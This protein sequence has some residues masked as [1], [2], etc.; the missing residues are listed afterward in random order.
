MLH[1]G[2]LIIVTHQNIRK[3]FENFYFCAVEGG[4]LL[5]QFVHTTGAT[6]PPRNSNIRVVGGPCP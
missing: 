2:Y 1:K 5:M 6:E 3:I 4:K